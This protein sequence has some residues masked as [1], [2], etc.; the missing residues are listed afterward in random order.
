[1]PSSTQT[2]K[3]QPKS[4]SS[5]LHRHDKVRDGSSDP[6]PPYKMQRRSDES[7]VS[8]HGDGT[9]HGKAKPSQTIRGKNGKP[10]SGVLNL[11]R[12][13]SFRFKDYYLGKGSISVLLFYLPVEILIDNCCQRMAVVQSVSIVHSKAWYT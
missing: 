6:T 7:P 10:G 8:R 12:I 3:Y 5:S 9:G 2:H 13:L 4:Q 1:M 11:H